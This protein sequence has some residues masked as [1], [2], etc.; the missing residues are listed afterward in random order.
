MNCS[1]F[2]SRTESDFK[3]S[4]LVFET[5]LAIALGN[6]QWNRLRRTQPLVSSLSIRTAED[7]AI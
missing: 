1:T 6:V 7:F 4:I 3:E 5:L 2:K